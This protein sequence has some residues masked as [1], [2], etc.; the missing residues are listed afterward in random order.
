MNVLVSIVIRPLAQ[1]LSMFGAQAEASCR[2]CTMF[3]SLS[4]HY[5]PPEVSELSWLGTVPVWAAACG[6]PDSPGARAGSDIEAGTSRRPRTDQAGSSEE[7][8]SSE[9]VSSLSEEESSSSE[10]EQ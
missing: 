10:D 2:R 7:D 3:G 9:E 8:S 1:S 6:S 4:V 5:D